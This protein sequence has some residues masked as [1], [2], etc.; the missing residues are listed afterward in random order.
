MPRD[1]DKNN[2]SRGR[3]DRP[4]GGKGRSGA[5]RG[6][7]KKFAKRGFAGKSDGDKR[8]GER[9]PY[10]GKSDGPRSYAK[11]PYAGGGK[12]YAGKRDGDAPRPRGDRPSGD[13]PQRFNRDDRSGGGE[14]RPYTPRGERSFSDRPSRDG[15][16]KRPYT[17]RDHGDARPAARFQDKKFGEK[18]PYT[19]REGGGEKR[20]YTPRGDRPQGDRPYSVRPSRDGDRPRGDRPERKFGGDKKFSR[21]APDRGPR[22][23]FGSR[24][25]KSDPGDR[26]SDRG[27]SKPWQKRD[28]SS[29]DHAGRNSR[30]PRD[31]ARNFDKPRGDRPQGDRPFRER[32]KFD[33]PREGRDERPRGD[34]PQGDRPRFNREDRPK[35]DRPR[36]RTRESGEGRPS[37][38]EHP[39][40][41]ARSERPRRDNEDDSKVFAKRPAFGGRGE[42]RERKPDF[43]KRAARPPREKKS[44]ERIAKVLSRAGLASRRDAEEWIVQGRV[45]V[46]GRV[47]NS[48]ALDVTGND[49]ITIDGKPLPPR[50]RTR[51]FMFHKPRGLM[52][53]HSDPEGRPTV[54]DNLPEGLP[55]LISIGRLDFN[56]EG[57]LL[58]TNDGGLAR[59]LELPDTGWLRRYR[60]RAH[61]EVTQAQLD[62]LKKGVE[63]DGVKYGSID[64]TL[65]RDQGANVWL[66]FA[67]REGKNREVRN[68]MA[69]LGLEV[70]RLIRVSYGPFQ[71]GELGEGEVE[72]VKTRV[73]REQ[74]GEKIAEL[75]GADFNRPMPGDA[76]AKPDDEDAPHGKKPFK[77]A[78]K[79]G[80]IADRKG[81]RILVQRTGSD[82]AR[83]RNEAE[84]SGY[85]PP[86]RPQR[87]YHGKRDIKPRDE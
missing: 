19:P 61:G 65:E 48:P 44:G 11:K 21:G 38:Q 59:A 8:D 47:I 70:N 5:A 10:A 16:E 27:E 72:E 33:R 87:G 23:D 83:A 1:S 71:L 40:S 4:S 25:R 57:L 52:T 15:G 45:T 49:V 37:W 42:Y 17:P 30:P 7:E 82:E 84:A 79:S 50:E 75:A 6:P 56:T 64:A 18:R 73:L 13:R 54:F 36:D 53:T 43:E 81:R 68:V 24:D 9:K 55:R 85:G 2:D 26:G 32:P 35:F 29:P 41:D 76:N 77:P 14:K 62:E 12:P 66:V 28:A 3:R 63:V 86:R 69:H 51:L 58:L 67:I 60:V 78:G 74:L 20:P 34:R 39:R 80:L 22:K 31:G 46:N